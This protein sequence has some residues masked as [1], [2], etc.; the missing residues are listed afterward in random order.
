LSIIFDSFSESIEI[1]LNT[2]TT[3]FDNR[4]K[5]ELISCLFSL[6]SL[7]ISFEI[8]I[9]IPGRKYA[10]TSSGSVLRQLSSVLINWH[11]FIIQIM[12]RIDSFLSKLYFSL[13]AMLRSI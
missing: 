13:R 6:S 8:L 9:E 11:L 10:I 1:V 5:Q 2:K 3:V 7:E 4:V 12:V